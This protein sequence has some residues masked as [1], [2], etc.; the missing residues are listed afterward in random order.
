MAAK[1]KP[2]DAESRMSMPDVTMAAH[3]DNGQ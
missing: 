1:K 3:K 2:M